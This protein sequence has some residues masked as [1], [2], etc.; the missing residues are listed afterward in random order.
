MPIRVFVCLIAAIVA[1]VASPAAQPLTSAERNGF[2]LKAAGRFVEARRAFFDACPK[3]K[4]DNADAL[5]AELCMELIADAGWLAG[6]AATTRAMLDQ[7]LASELAAQHR[8]LFE[9]VSLRAM[10]LADDAGDVA[11]RDRYGEQIGTLTSW[12]L[13]GPF[14]NE[15][16][17]GYGT[18]YG[19]ERE[20]DLEASYT[21]KKRPVRWRRL[22]VDPMPMGKV[23]LDAC[24]RPNDQVLCYVA[25]VIQAEKAEDVVLHLGSDE[26]FAVF[27]NRTKVA[28]RDLRRPFRFDQDACV[29]PLRAGANLLVLKVCDQVGGFAVAAADQSGGPRTRGDQ[30]PLRCGELGRGGAHRTSRSRDAGS[31]FVGSIVG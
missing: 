26:A 27:L 28:G 5:R 12:W 22:S 25:T 7:I 2:E 14:D 13:C 19:P 10:R 20:L 1:T 17:G 9:R 24:V 30:H 3:A 31:R 18:V 15:R 8:R 16:G 4:G 29:L 11:A 6:D 23:D 21:G